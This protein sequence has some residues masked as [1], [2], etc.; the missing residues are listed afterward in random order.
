MYSAGFYPYETLEEYWAYWSRHISVNRYGQ[1]PGKPYETLLELVK[2]KDYFVLTTNVDHRFQVAG[3]DKRRL[4]YTQG[5]YGLWQCSRPCCQKT[6][7]NEKIVVQ[8]VKEQK[9]L[10]I[11]SHLIPYCPVCGAPMSMNLRA[12]AAF[13]EDKGWHDAADRY[14][15]FLQRHR[16]LHVLYLE[17][18]VGA[19]TPGIIKYPFWQMT[20]QNENA[21]YA[22]INMQKPYVPAEIKDRSICINGDI[23]STLEE[24][25]AK[26]VAAS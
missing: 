18:G 6:Y 17:L 21:V 2:G 1:P 9:D 3:F 16:G 22:C 11:P 7:D 25:K 26:S 5:D 23:G 10:R 15:E 13:A 12:D 8:M 20:F 14:Q 24:L 19:N 4:F